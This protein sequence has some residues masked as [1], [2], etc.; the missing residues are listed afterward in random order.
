MEHVLEVGC[1]G[2]VKRRAG[3]VLVAWGIAAGCDPVIEGDEVEPDYVIDELARGLIDCGERADTGYR[4]GSPFPITVV[5]VDGK[6]AERDTA[7]AYWVMQQAAA[8]DGVNIAIVSGF[9]TNA[10]Q[11]YLYG[12]Y[13]N[14][15]CNNCNLAARPGYS[16]HQS[17]HALDLN[18]SDGRVLS[19]LNTNGAR[20]G[21]ERTVPSE[22]WHWEWWGGGPGG[23]PCVDRPC[24]KLAPQG[25]MIDDS[26]ACFTAFG[27]SPYWR[28][29]EGEGHRGGLKWTNAF[30]SGAPSNW[31][32]WNIDL[33]SAGDYQ[34][35]VATGGSYGVFAETR[36]GIRHDGVEDTIIVDQSLVSGWQDLGVYS[37]E[38]GGDQW[39]AV[40][41]NYSTNVQDDLH[42]MAD[43]IRV[44]PYVEPVIP[45]APVPPLSSGADADGV[46]IGEVPAGAVKSAARR[47]EL[48]AVSVSGGCSATGADGSLL[49]LAYLFL[50]LFGCRRRSRV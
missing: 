33:S 28:I 9:R 27:P 23:G 42:I 11:T 25:G 32:R 30:A 13:V 39:V 19:W 6:P 21:F 48:A 26:D 37:F 43:A 2:L 12:C 5:T 40:Y 16:N 44:T 10:E 17:G 22:N 1:Y 34:I 45:P 38:A 18:T 3:V 14:C 4:S 47:A 8:R 50:A 24:E 29:V 20:F 36:Y 31:A 46:P 15:N 7:N 35:E 49:P 41:D